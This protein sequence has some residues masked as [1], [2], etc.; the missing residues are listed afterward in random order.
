MLPIFFRPRALY[1]ASMS[2]L[3]QGQLL[4]ASPEL[5]DPSFFHAA[6]L[7]V[8]HDESGA[9][10]L[11][12]NR[13][14][15]VTLAQAWQSDLIPCDVHS[16]LYQGGPCDGPLM[17]LHAHEEHA[18][19]EVGDGLFFS[20]DKDAIQ[21][22][23]AQKIPP[24]KF[25]A[26]YAGWAAGQLDAEMAQNAWT[27]AA[28]NSVDVLADAGDELWRRLYRQQAG[29]GIFFANIPPQALPRDASSN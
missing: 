11:V 28:P 1:N 5:V 9:M 21:S 8:Q 3:L 12:I 25:F 26:G 24:M 10:G 6:V 19:V 27:V 15:N 4:L 22:L 29:G 17:V 18:Q 14:T 20:I 2:T 16:P 23:V 7:I 13:P